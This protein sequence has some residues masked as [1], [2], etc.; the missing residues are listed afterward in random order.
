MGRFRY[1]LPI[2]SVVAT[3]QTRFFKPRSNF[4]FAL[5]PFARGD[6]LFRRRISFEKDLDKRNLH[7]SLRPAF[8]KR[9]CSLQ[10]RWM[11]DQ[12]N[13]LIFLKKNLVVK[14]TVLSSPPVRQK[15][16]FIEARL[17]ELL[18]K[19]FE[20]NSNKIWWRKKASYLCSPLEKT[21]VL[22]LIFTAKKVWNFFK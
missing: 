3:R 15:R 7:L 19:K 20:E 6:L 9:G 8:K 11:V 13:F 10:I 18:K 16:M 17:R 21:V 22:N 2:F 1:F 5:K 4:F 14:T 12:Q